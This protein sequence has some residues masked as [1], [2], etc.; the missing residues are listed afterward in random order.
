MSPEQAEGRSVDARSDIFAFGAVL[1]EMLTGQR[2]FQ[3]ESRIATLAA[4]LNEEPKPAVELN[5]TLPPDI[6]TVLARCLRKDPQRRWQTMADLKVVLQDLKDDSESGKLRRPEAA[7]KRRRVPILVRIGLPAALVTAAALLWVLRPRDRGPVEYEITRMTFDSGV[8]WSPC[9]SPDGKMFAYSSNRGGQGRSDIWLQQVAGG[10]PLRMTTDGAGNNFPCFSPD[11][12]KVA[13][14]SGLTGALYE[15]GLLGGSPRK[16][17]SHGVR[18][19]YSP[20]GSQIACLSVPATFIGPI[21]I[22]LVPGEGGEPVPFQPDYSVADFLSGAGPLWSPDGRFI[23]FN[24]QRIGDPSSRDW[25]VAPISGGPPIRTGAHASLRLSPVW[26]SPAAWTGNYVYYC[27]GTMVEGVNIYRVRFD[28]KTFKVAG[29]PERIT[30][31][32][33]SQIGVSALPDGRLV[34]A[35]IT[36]LSTIFTVGSRPDEGLV[37]G[38]P[39][40]LSQDAK[41]KF[42]PALSRDG[43]RLVYGVFGG[44]RNDLFEVRVCDL[45]SGREKAIPVEASEFAQPPRISPDGTVISY[46]DVR[47]GTARTFVVSANETS[48]REACATCSIFGFYSD[49]R[50]ALVEDTDAPLSKF[51]LSTGIRTPVL[52]N[53]RGRISE[54]ALS[55][56]DRWIAFILGKADGRAALALAPLAAAPAPERDWIVLFDENAYLGSP[57]WSPNGR[58]LYYLSERDGACKVWCQPLDPRSKRPVGASRIVFDPG[59][60]GVDLNMPRGNGTVTVGRDKLAIWAGQATGNIYMAAPRRNK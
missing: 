12:T 56:D 10:A 50:Y 36:W 32:A 9:F 2:A 60:F 21:T 47:S 19:R 43:S 1:Y 18:P 54:A 55:P 4:I 22:L 52:E 59:P 42:S 40:Y 16:L 48:G 39:E 45:A 51:D 44:L 14:N 49:P 38:V 13:F 58:I 26:Q 8:T 31:G 25:W 5:E 7:A 15:I 3:R 30:S 35:H 29:P 23:L 41:A 37:T 46:R 28:P 33:G 6:E 11:G 20:D 17:A 34:Y 24:G 27:I 57:A 53:G